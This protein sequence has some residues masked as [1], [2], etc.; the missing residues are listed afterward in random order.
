[1]GGVGG[2][3]TAGALGATGA[4]TERWAAGRGAAGTLRLTGVRCVLTITEARRFQVVGRTTGR[5]TRTGRLAGA[6]AFCS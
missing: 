3:V 5:G 1:V 4:I 2:C 6:E